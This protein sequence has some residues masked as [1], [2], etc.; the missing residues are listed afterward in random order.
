VIEE[1]ARVEVVGEV[2]QEAA[3]ALAHFVEL[4]GVGETFV[5]PPAG[6]PRAHLEVYLRLRDV[7][8]EPDDRER[9]AQPPCGDARV[10]ARGRLILLHVHTA[11]VALVHVDRDVVLV[12][13]GIVHAVGVYA[14]ARGP[15]SE[16]AQVLA[17]PVREHLGA[18]SEIGRCGDGLALAVI[19]GLAHLEMQELALDRSVVERVQ[20]ACAQAEALPERGI[21]SQ[22]GRAPAAIAALERLAELLVERP[23]RCG[24]AHALAVGRVGRDET[25][26]GRVELRTLAERADREAHAGGI[27][28]GARE[29]AA[30]GF[31]RARVP[32]GARQ[33]REPAASGRPARLG[34]RAQPR[35][36]GRVVAEPALEAEAR[37]QEPRRYVG[38]DE[39]GFEHERAR[40]AHGIHERRALGRER[41]PAG[42]HQYR[43]G[44]G[45]LERSGGRLRAVTPPVQA[46]AREVDAERRLVVA[47]MQ[48]DAHVGLRGVDRGTPTALGA[49]PVDDRVFHTQR[50][51][52]RM[53]DRGIGDHRIDGEGGLGRQVFTP[54]DR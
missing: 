52:V 32:V 54:R 21:A 46:L 16:V 44:E 1:E 15:A 51:V 47:Q 20:P 36:G 22:Y 18:R 3:R 19:P 7:E 41:R 37:P 27:E 11:A 25:G 39:R 40:A 2:H 38:G 14:L 31:D 8:H 28:P 26:A 5:L 6:L 9:L 12:K 42:A 4:A 29:I 50:R 10:D 34:F 43:G 17:Q 35:P 13:I 24:F 45:F 30:R 53:R 49:Q 23:E 48:V 33:Q